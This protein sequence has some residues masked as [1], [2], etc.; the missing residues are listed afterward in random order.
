MSFLTNRSAHDEDDDED[1]DE[2]LVYIVFENDEP[3][4]HQSSPGERLLHHPLA[5]WTHVDC[6]RELMPFVAHLLPGLL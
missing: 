2:Q 1:D 3:L 5:L 6:E 4:F